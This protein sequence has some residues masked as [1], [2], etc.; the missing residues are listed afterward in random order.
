MQ[1]KDLGVNPAINNSQHKSDAKTRAGGDDFFRLMQEKIGKEQPAAASESPGIHPTGG[2]GE[3]EA[4]AARSRIIKPIA[5]NDVSDFLGLVKENRHLLRGVD[6]DALNLNEKAAGNAS[7]SA[8]QASALQKEFDLGN[9][10]PKQL[11]ELFEQLNALNVLSAD[12][13]RSVRNS[14]TPADGDVMDYL[15]NE[16]GF[17]DVSSISENDPKARLSAMMQNEKFAS[18]HI[19]AR[20]GQNVPSVS[21]LADMHKKVLGVLGKI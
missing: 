5:K 8:E 21:A 14:V 3:I 13:I 12:E 10:T 7:L 15:L 4:I 16:Q 9:I 11:S 20:Y 1:I 19:N 6:L 2:I 17:K 18:L